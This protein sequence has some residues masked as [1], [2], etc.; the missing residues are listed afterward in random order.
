MHGSMNIKFIKA[1][2]AT[3]VHAYKNTKRKLHKTNAAIW[4]N[5]TC[6]DKKLTP[7]YINIKNGGIINTITRLHLVGYFY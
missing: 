5:E 1:K 6:R 3:D 2:Q 4:F 7:N